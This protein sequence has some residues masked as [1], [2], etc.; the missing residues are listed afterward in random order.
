MI[1]VELFGL[2]CFRQ[3]SLGSNWC[4]C[5]HL[6]FIAL[7]QS[8]ELW[9]LWSC[10]VC[11]VSGFFS[12]RSNWC[13][14]HVLFIA[15]MT[16]C[17][18]VLKRGKSSNKRFE[19]FGKSCHNCLQFGIKDCWLSLLISFQAVI[20]LFAH[21][22]IYVY[23]LCLLPLLIEVLNPSESWSCGALLKNPFTFSV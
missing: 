17:L 1:I 14:T 21:L 2:S 9:L 23:L 22:C 7:I 3:F 18:N 8:S 4:C 6:L 19:I 12:L 10:L 11:L 5:I 20:Y 15:L 13:C 16:N